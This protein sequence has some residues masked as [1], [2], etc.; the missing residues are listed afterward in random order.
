MNFLKFKFE[1]NKIDA[2]PIYL[3][4]AEELDDWLEKKKDH[5]KNWIKS[6]GFVA[7]LGEVCLIPD[8]LGNLEQV[9]V[10]LGSK[11]IRKRE[12]LTIGGVT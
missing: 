3:L 11:P 5:L 9:L 1:L 2:C 7:G 10:G 8:S 6:N 12:R 4:K